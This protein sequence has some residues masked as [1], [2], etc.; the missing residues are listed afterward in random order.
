[1]HVLDEPSRAPELRDMHWFNLEADGFA[2][3]LTLSA[4]RGRVVLID[5]WD[6]TCINCLHT[7]DYI[8]EWHRRYR[9]QGLVV[10]GVHTPEFAFA[11]DAAL[12]EAAA[13]CLELAYPIAVDSAYA[14]WKAF[15]NRFWPAKYLI[16][17]D[18]N[19]RAFH[20]GEGAYEEFEEAIQQLLRET[21]AS[22][23]FPA[24]MAPVRDIDRPGAVCHRPTPEL[25]LGYDRGELG[26]REGNPPD[27]TIDYPPPP[28]QRFQDTVYLEGAWQNAQE[29]VETVS[30][31]PARIHLDYRA[32]Q[33]NLV[34]EPAGARPVTLF[35]YQDGEPLPRAHWGADVELIDGKP[36]L[37][38]Q[39][40]RMASLVSNPDFGAHRLM[41]EIRQAG[42][43]AYAF[44]FV[45]SICHHT[46]IA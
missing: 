33:V 23:A 27:S 2:G 22:L 17:K 45:G 30:H 3:P 29:Y 20:I 15:A 11:R 31:Q 36:A 12:V 14:T 38:M 26:N 18:G 8:K 13:R 37:D 39:V 9:A 43:R 24:P 35:I 28:A 4:L 19:I 34:L 44:T 32:A 16:D 42:L 5:F 46:A 40:P 1:M 41:L 25:Y 21:D 10:I 6:Y 7:L